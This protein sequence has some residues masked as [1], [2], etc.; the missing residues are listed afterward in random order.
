MPAQTTAPASAKRHVEENLLRH[1][2]T[3]ASSRFGRYVD[4][5]PENS[6]NLPGRA[7]G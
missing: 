1:L 4:A 2:I 6:K 3:I 5:L 7:A